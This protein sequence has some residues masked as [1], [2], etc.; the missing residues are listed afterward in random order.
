MYFLIWIG[1]IFVVWM[2]YLEFSSK[3]GN[4]WWRINSKGQREFQL[5]GLLSMISYPLK[6]MNFWNP[7]FWDLNIYV[8]LAIFSVIYFVK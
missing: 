1:L 2:I 6:N 8:I 3:L 7:Q 4:I 5:D